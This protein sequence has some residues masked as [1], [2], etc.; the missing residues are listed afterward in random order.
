VSHQSRVSFRIL[1]SIGRSWHFR[2]QHHIR[3]HDLHNEAHKLT[4]ELTTFDLPHSY[5]VSLLEGQN[6]IT[7]LHQKCHQRCSQ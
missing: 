2:I 4:R 6:G 7:N 5:R 3:P 1:T